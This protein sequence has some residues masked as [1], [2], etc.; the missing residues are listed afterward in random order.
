[1]RIKHCS[2]VVLNINI[3]TISEKLGR[4]IINS[5]N[6]NFFYVTIFNLHM[7]TRSVI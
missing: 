2:T 7:M 4:R 6:L 1:M 3:L 5:S